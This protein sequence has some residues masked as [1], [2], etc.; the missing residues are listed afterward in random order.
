MDIVGKYEEKPFPRL[1]EI[2][3]DE[4]EQSQ[5]INMRDTQ[6]QSSFGERA[7]NQTGSH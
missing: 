7:K 4:L 5:I 2:T 6:L 1:C 3:V